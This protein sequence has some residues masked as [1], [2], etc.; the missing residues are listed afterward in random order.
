VPSLLVVG[1]QRRYLTIDSH[2]LAEMVGIRFKPGGFVPFVGI[3]AVEFR[4]RYVP[5]EA[6]WGHGANRI[7]ERLLAEPSPEKKLRLVEQA[8]FEH[9]RGD[10]C[11]HATTVSALADVE[12]SACRG[13]LAMHLA[14]SPDLIEW[15]G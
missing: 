15:A 3:P 2:D 6:V 9:L 12:V 11:Q 8:P 7:R 14:M 5:L 13:D 1:V 4:D 10:A